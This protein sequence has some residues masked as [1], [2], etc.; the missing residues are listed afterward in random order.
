[1][2][3]TRIFLPLLLSLVCLSAGAQVPVPVLF[4][5]PALPQLKAYLGLTDAQIS[6][7]AGNLTQ[8]GQL[9]NQRQQRMFQVQGEIQ[10]ETATIPLDPEAL[11]MRYA[12]IETICRNVKDEA[13]AAQNRNLALLTDA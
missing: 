1:M 5:Q 4:P 12:E 7:I 9:V 11:G 2:V 6:Q 3:K 13:T 8:Y 10:Q